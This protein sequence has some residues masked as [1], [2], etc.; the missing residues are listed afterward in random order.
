M[1]TFTGAERARCV[2]WFEETKSAT[3]V[4]RNFRT[5]YGKDPPSR[6]TIY[7]W[8]KNFVE[9]G[10][11]FVTFFTRKSALDAQNALHNIKT[12]A[13]SIRGVW[14]EK[15]TN[16]VY[17]ELYYGEIQSFE[18]VDLHKD[19][20][21]FESRKPKS[22][23]RWPVPTEYCKATVVNF[24]SHYHHWRIL[25]N[26]QVVQILEG[27]MFQSFCF[28]HD[29][30][31]N[32]W[33]GERECPNTSVQAGCGA[34]SA[35]YQKDAE[36]FILR[37][38]DCD[39]KL[40]T[41]VRRVP[42]E[43]RKLWIIWK[44][45]E[46]MTTAVE[47]QQLKNRI[48]LSGEASCG[49][50]PAG[51]PYIDRRSERQRN[52]SASHGR[53][54]RPR[55]LSAE[56]CGDRL[57]VAGNVRTTAP[58]QKV[59]TRTESITMAGEKIVQP[60][61]RYSCLDHEDGGLW[62]V[63][64]KARIRKESEYFLLTQRV[65]HRLLHSPINPEQCSFSDSQ[66]SESKQDDILGGDPGYSAYLV[67]ARQPDWFGGWAQLSVVVAP[68][69]SIDRVSRVFLARYQLLVN[70]LPVYTTARYIVGIQTTEGFNHYEDGCLLNCLV[71][72]CFDDGGSKDLRNV[73]KLLPD[74]TT[75][76]FRRQPP[77]YFLSS[78]TNRLKYRLLKRYPALRGQIAFFKMNLHTALNIITQ[79][80]CC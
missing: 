70:Y 22:V 79:S 50:H 8:H 41:H 11:C 53:S 62:V 20:G 74:Y 3:M 63:R 31:C 77:S 68:R 7:S 73:G 78:P 58:Q 12:L 65:R 30:K 25:K 35:S 40:T 61:E 64:L 24:Q 29:Y 33:Y 52:E 2:L 46:D 4:Q 56:R 59:S 37:S 42:T 43:K 9:T 80:V 69:K 26:L 28:K 48:Q 1:A 51:R 39:V 27:K 5:Q 57:P 15:K 54:A 60:E 75:L 13:G 38:S 66:Y 72:H 23:I 16:S 36:F 44:T 71:D 6:P 14:R 21:E 34:Y 45:V 17:K 32:C 47:Q 10:C 55:M 19:V 49:I 67:G 76:L 18:N